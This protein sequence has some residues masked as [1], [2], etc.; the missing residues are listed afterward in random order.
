[1][2]KD[3]KQI[4]ILLTGG[5]TGGHITPLMA[6]VE[7]LKKHNCD[8]LF[9]GSGL[10]LEEKAAKKLTVKYQSIL[11]GKLR[12]YFS[13]QNFIDPFKVIIGFF[14]SLGII[15]SFRP[16][17]IFAKGGYVTMPVVLAAW[18][19]RVP[20]IT[21]ESDVI[22]GL[23]NRLEAKL[24][25]K[26]CVGFP[27]EN[28]KDLPLHKIVYTGNPIRKEFL[29]AKRSNDWNKRS[30][31]TTGTILVTGGSQGSR[32]IN[33]T[34]AALLG[35][36]TKKY[37]I[38]HVS[39]KNDHEWLKKNSWPNYELYDFTDKIAQLMNKADLIISRSGASTL[40]EISVL[41]KPSILIPLSTSAN[42]HQQANAKIYE[43]KSAAVVV[44]EKGLTSD[45]LK[46]IIDR[47]MEDKK[48]LEEISKNTKELSQP[49]AAE[50]ITE[51]ILRVI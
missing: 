13:W 10:D 24:A 46:D 3:K 29:Q 5:G 37:H 9:V 14:Q 21:H 43:K 28:Y 25:K 40:A 33:Q 30:D 6:V 31:R 2:I 36:L 18:F 47:L 12:R 15:V 19:L 4:K 38:I 50:A 1:M 7:A 51:E 22:M 35:E 16:K 17:V 26:I 11:S 42:E 34:I 49:N 39:G 23:A 20:I 48:M 32:F 41:G 27:V 45:N 44:S 8:I